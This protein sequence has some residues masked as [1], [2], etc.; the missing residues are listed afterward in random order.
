MTEKLILSMGGIPAELSN[1]QV[2]VADSVEQALAYY[3]FYAPHGIV[4]DAQ[5]P[6]AVEVFSH[7]SDV[8]AASPRGTEI[9]VIYNADDTW[10]TPPKTVMIQLPDEI[11]VLAALESALSSDEVMLC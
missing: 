10:V 5:D 3:L 1:E 7:L 4:L 9:M 11:G 2:I 8:T 6:Q